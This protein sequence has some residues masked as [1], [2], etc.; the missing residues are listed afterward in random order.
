MIN[1]YNPYSGKSLGTPTFKSGG[2]A[3]PELLNRI[4]KSRIKSPGTQKSVVQGGNLT[5]QMPNVFESDATALQSNAMSGQIYGGTSEQRVEAASLAGDSAPPK[6]GGGF[7][8]KPGLT[9]GLGL[10]GAAISELDTDDKYG[11]MDVAASTAKYA[12]MGAMAGPIGAGVGALVGAGI[13]LFKKKKFEKEA[14]KKKETDRRK[15]QEQTQKDFRQEEVE[16]F[17]GK[18]QSA[19]AGSYGGADVDMFINKYAQ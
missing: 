15:N 18:Q 1:P 12:A 9:A 17:F 7:E 3:V 11:G 13:G 14:K 6:S 4:Q 5:P 2:Y 8:A 19:V 16:E 10:A